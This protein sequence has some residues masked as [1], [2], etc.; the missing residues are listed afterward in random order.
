M[1][2][3]AQES[4][5]TAGDFSAGLAFRAFAPFAVGYFLAS[6]FRS[7]NAVIASELARDFEIGGAGLGFAVSALFLNATLCQLPYGVLLDRYDPRRLYASMLLFSA[8]G[9]VLSAVAE[10]ILVLALGRALVALG[11]Q[12]V[13]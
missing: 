4:P 5:T 1:T 6:I 13:A 8:L 9:A 12:R 3:P 2:G 7:I 11:W 10:N